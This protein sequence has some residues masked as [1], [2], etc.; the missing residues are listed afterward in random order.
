[1]I[2]IAHREWVKAPQSSGLYLAP[3]LFPIWLDGVTEIAVLK[4]AEIG[5]DLRYVPSEAIYGFRTSESTFY[6]EVTT[7]LFAG[8]KEE[9]GNTSISFMGTGK[10]T[11]AET[12]K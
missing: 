9:G 6:A 11:Q 5:V 3:S 1:M 8:F 7:E 2:D 12:E 4:D 10:E